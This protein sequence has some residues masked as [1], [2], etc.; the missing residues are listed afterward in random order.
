M[1]TAN[2]EEFVAHIKTFGWEACL[3]LLDQ[4]AKKNNIKLCE[5][6]ERLFNDNYYFDF[7]LGKRNEKIKLPIGTKININ[8]ES[9]EELN[10]NLPFKVYRVGEDI[11]NLE[12]YETEG[13]TLNAAI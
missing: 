1:H 4:Y 5:A 8:N 11:N 13:V 6:G 7:R 10:N 9:L 3:P 2:D 12:E